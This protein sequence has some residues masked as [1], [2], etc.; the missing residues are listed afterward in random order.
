[1]ARQ[2]IILGT[3]PTGLGGDPPRTASTKINAMTQEL[4]GVTNNL[5]TASTKD[6]QTS[7]TDNTDGRL[8]LVGAFGGNGGSSIVMSSSSDANDLSMSGNYLFSNGGLNLPTG[9]P[10]PHIT[11]I[12]AGSGYSTQIARSSTSIG[13]AIRL[14]FAGSFGPWFT[15]YTSANAVSSVATGGLIESGSSANGTYTKWADGT[16]QASLVIS[17]LG[18][19]TD[20]AL[21]TLFYS[22]DV[23]AATN[24]AAAFIAPPEVSVFV[25]SINYGGV[26][27]GCTNRGTASA[28]PRIVLISPMVFTSDCIIEITARGRWKN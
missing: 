10:F 8:L 26:I 17:K 13:Q 16:M 24:Y 11:V 18:I 27:A 2:E 3:A 25:T 12:S 23:V 9:A 14:Q 4:Y 19:S 1:M 5:K 7:K 21:G 28:S 22:N 6:A 20:A 15:F